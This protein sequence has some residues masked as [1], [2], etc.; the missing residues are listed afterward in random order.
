[1]TFPGIFLAADSE[2]FVFAVVLDFLPPK[3]KP[4]QT[5]NFILA[6]FL[7]KENYKLNV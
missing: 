4:N 3:T 5:Q 2:T 6:K 7:M 1:V